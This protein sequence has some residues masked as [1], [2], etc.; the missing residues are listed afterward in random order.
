[1]HPEGFSRFGHSGH[2]AHSEGI[3]KGGSWFGH[4]GH[5]A[6]SECIR[7]DFPGLGTRDT[8]HTRNA[9]GGVALGLGTRDTWHTRNAS[10]GIFPVW[11]LG[12]RGTL[13]MHPEGFSLGARLSGHV[14]S[15]GD[16]RRV[17]LGLG[18]RDTWRAWED[19]GESSPGWSSRD[20]WRT[21]NAPGGGATGWGHLVGQAYQVGR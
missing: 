4:S 7:R 10:G 5:V 20:A 8:W 12:T 2:V 14:E 6:Y 19:P 1:M 16:I 17:A 21:R 15:S 11:A 9:S 3:P 13:G 18:F